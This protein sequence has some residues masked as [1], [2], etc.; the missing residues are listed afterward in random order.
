MHM[1]PFQKKIRKKRENKHGTL[2]FENLFK[3]RTFLR[4]CIL[5]EKL[6]LKLVYKLK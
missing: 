4:T 1:G 2:D 6:S 5:F 3:S